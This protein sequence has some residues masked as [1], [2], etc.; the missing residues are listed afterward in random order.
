MLAAESA[1]LVH[2]KTIRGI[3]LIL[4]RIVVALLALVA[5]EC[6]LDSHLAAPPF[7]FAPPRRGGCL[8]EVQT[9]IVK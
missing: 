3:L 1:I 2:L 4:D 7:L 5:P 8:P 9:G 6:D